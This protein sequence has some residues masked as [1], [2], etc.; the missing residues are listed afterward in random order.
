MRKQQFQIGNSTMS[1]QELLEKTR[2]QEQ[3]ENYVFKNPWDQNSSYEIH[4]TE[5]TAK[6]GNYK[7]NNPWDENSVDELKQFEDTLKLNDYKYKATWVKNE[8]SILEESKT[9]TNSNYKYESLWAP[10]AMS[11]EE[12]RQIKN[13]KYDPP[14]G[15][16]LNKQEDEVR[17]ARKTNSSR[18]AALAPWQLGS[19]PGDKVHRNIVPQPKTTLWDVPENEN[20]NKATDITSS[21][22]PILDSLRV[23]LRSRGAAGILGLSK[24]FKI[25]DDDNSGALDMVEFEKA[26]RECEISDLSSKAIRHLFRYFDKDDS[27]SITY[28]EF[29]VGVRGELNERRKTMV[30]MAYNKLDSDGSGVLTIDD[31]KD[32]YDVS[33]HPDYISGKQTKNALLTEFLSN[34]IVKKKNSPLHIEEVTEQDFLRYYANLSA[35]IDS[36]DY[37]ELMIRNAWHIAG[38]SG[39]C[40]NTTNKRVLVTNTRTGAQSVVDI[41]SNKQYNDNEDYAIENVSKFKNSTSGGSTGG[42]KAK[43]FS[44][45]SQLS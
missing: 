44:L 14:F 2:L 43:S 4:K 32:V 26:M 37:F 16:E 12:L 42:N 13:Y 8:S 10:K 39:W 45:M 17:S 30:I 33:S 9:K 5:Q 11:D 36:D 22:D 3:A 25:M 38:G 34:F 28:D 18:G 23:Q 7:F 19:I 15:S 35:S 24:K 6:A 29:L 40:E 31:L 1:K 27:G 41:E 21:G 20:A